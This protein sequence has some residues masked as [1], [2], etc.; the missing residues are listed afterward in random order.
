MG[1][2][3]AGEDFHLLHAV[4]DGAQ[5]HH[6]HAGGGAFLQFIHKLFCS[7]PRKGATALNF[8]FAIS[9][10]TKRLYVMKQ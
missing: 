10:F 4:E 5:D 3:F 8:T 2:H 1:D 7:E 9:L 6:L